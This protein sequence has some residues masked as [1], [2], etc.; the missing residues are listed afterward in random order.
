MNYII[1]DLEATCWPGSPPDRTRE[2][3]EI[4]AVKLNAYGEVKGQYRRFVKPVVHPLLSHFC[5]ELT[6]ITQQDVQRASGFEEVLEDW[7]DWMGYY[8]GDDY[9]LASWGGSD[10]R[11]LR[12][13]CKL[14]KLEDDWTDA[15]IN[16]KEQYRVMKKLREP[17]G[18][19]KALDREGFE[20]E[21]THHR[22]LDD[23]ANLAQ[24]FVKYL[25]EWQ[26]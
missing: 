7:L 21:G 12:N 3:I 2:I 1:F 19:K 15:F 10:Q 18:L 4:G 25:G 9:L 24:I 6:S 26:Y 13:D 11:L 22:A 8:D 23:A 14:H 5:T 16:L 17:V 20:F